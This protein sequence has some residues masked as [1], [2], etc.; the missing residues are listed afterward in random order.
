[1]PSDPQRR[2]GGCLLQSL[3]YLGQISYEHGDY[4]E[5]R[6]LY[7]EALGLNRELENSRGAQRA[8]WQLA[9]I[10][11]IE[12][13]YPE[14]HSCLRQVVPAVRDSGDRT[15]ARNLLADF[16]ELAA[17]QRQWERAAR[18]GGAVE[19][20]GRGDGAPLW[21]AHERA[22]PGFMAQARAAL[23]EAAFDALFAQGRPLTAGEALGEAMEQ[24]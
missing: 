12:G 9:R 7:E 19:S 6:A 17:R 11:Y 1:M 22:H 24:P 8:L 14:A 15:Q 13:R 3:R 10:A 16:A 4:G 21:P 18:L 5:A 23:G 20:V 2:R